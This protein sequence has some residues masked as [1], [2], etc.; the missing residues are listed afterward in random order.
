MHHHG[1]LPG[2]RLSDGHPVEVPE[3]LI[4]VNEI[5]VC[6]WLPGVLSSNFL[7]LACTQPLKRVKNVAEL[8]LI[9]AVVIPPSH[10]LPHVILASC[11]VSS[12]KLL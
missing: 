11:P 7:M 9:M 12:R 3:E 2:P 6:L 10:A 8:L 1:L 5:P 4:D